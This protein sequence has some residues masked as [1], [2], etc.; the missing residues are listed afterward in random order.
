MLRFILW[1]CF[2]YTSIQRGFAQGSSN[3]DQG[4]GKI[5]PLEVEVKLG[6]DVILQCDAVKLGQNSLLLEWRKNGSKSAIF[7]KFMDF[8]PRID[9]RYSRRLHMINSSAILLSSA[10]ESDAG[11]YRCKTMQSATESAVINH[12]RWIVLKVTGKVG[13]PSRRKTVVETYPAV[14]DCMTDKD[15][16]TETVVYSWTKDGSDAL[17]SVGATILASGA[18]FIKATR[19]AYIGVYQCTARTVDSTGLVSYAGVK[20]FLDVQYAPEIKNISEVVAV[21]EGSDARLPCVADAN[22]ATEFTNWTRHRKD[23]RSARF[24]V[25]EKGALLIQDVRRTDAGEYSCTPYNKVGA[26]KTKITKLVLKDVPRFIIAPPSIMTLRVDD[27]VTLDCRATSES[28]V[29]LS[30]EREGSPLPKD[31]S[32][33]KN[34]K[35]TIRRIQ[36]DDYGIYTCIASSNDGKA[37]QST[38]LAVIS[39]PSKPSITSVTFN[40][41]TVVVRWRPG[42]DGGYPQKMEVWYRLFSDDDY[43]WSYSPRLS[44]SVTSY[45]IPG[46]QAGKPYLFSVRGV[47]REGLGLFSEMVEAKGLPP[48]LNRDSKKSDKP[49]APESVTLNITR[50]GYHVSWQYKD[51][52][53][54]PSV[55]KFVIEYREGNHSSTW[56][57][58]DDNVPAERKDYLFSAKLAEADKSYDF[59]VSSCDATKCSEPAYVTV[60]YRIAS[61]VFGASSSGS[62]IYPIIGG[63]LGAICGVLLIALFCF[64]CC[65]KRKRDKLSINQSGSKKVQFVLPRSEGTE[66]E[67]SEED[68]LDAEIKLLP[69]A[70]RFVPDHNDTSYPYEKYAKMK[71]EEDFLLMGHGGCYGGDMLRRSNV[72]N[73]ASAGHSPELSLDSEKVRFFGDFETRDG[74][75]AWYDCSLGKPASREVR[76]SFDQ[77][78]RADIGSKDSIHRSPTGSNGRKSSQDQIGSKGAPK[79]GSNVSLPEGKA[80]SGNLRNSRFTPIKEESPR[81]RDVPRGNGTLGRRQPHHWSSPAVYSKRQD[82]NNNS[83]GKNSDSDSGD[84]SSRGRTRRHR[85]HSLYEGKLRPISEQDADAKLRCT[86]DAD[87]ESDDYANYPTLKLGE[88]GAPP[89]SESSSYLHLDRSDTLKRSFPNRSKEW[90]EPTPGEPYASHRHRKPLDTDS[91]NSISPAIS[92]ATLSETESDQ[93]IARKLYGSRSSE[94]TNG[95]VAAT[96]PRAV[97]KL[98]S[99]DSESSSDER[100]LQR[101][102]DRSRK[103]SPPVYKDK[104]PASVTD[105]ELKAVDRL[106]SM[107][108]LKACDPYFKN[109]NPVS[110]S[111]S[112]ASSGIGSVPVSSC[113]TNSIESPRE[114]RPRFSSRTSLDRA[115]SGYNSPRESLRS[116]SLRPSQMS[117]SARSS[118]SSDRTSTDRTSSG[119]TSSRDSYENTERLRP[120]DYSKAHAQMRL[121]GKGRRSDETYDLDPSS[122]DLH[123]VETEGSAYDPKVFEEIIAMQ[124]A[125]G[126]NLDGSDSSRESLKEMA[127]LSNSEMMTYSPRM[128]PSK[129]KVDLYSDEEKDQRCTKLMAEYK[130]NK[131]LQDVKTRPGSQI[132]RT[133]DL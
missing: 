75:S 20:T 15:L 129:F 81:E 38:T 100:G 87:E 105:L 58:A 74:Q 40:G 52:P 55:E 64:C 113:E 98:K 24:A 2:L 88:G 120:E 71:R 11:I 107:E 42:Y 37:R 82:T 116:S 36:K 77:F 127:K 48:E 51:V 12:G 39:T 122:H 19:R 54:R 65:R 92:L 33:V 56:F 131:K 34:G 111:S 118:V 47:N 108:L 109:C 78:C 106:D 104:K 5:P 103:S 53:G 117:T 18:L 50:D 83:D 1:T 90:N 9:P 112:N 4:G 133:W 73:S 27:D 31:R 8:T 35:L 110:R 26:G 59:R 67:E 101:S 123:E 17:T 119:Y 97:K 10:K 132:Y 44:A 66:P 6:S 121:S 7:M 80:T 114:R 43:K 16:P 94:T 29:T 13:L 61:P 69:E 49:L 3:T 76:D 70:V 28:P 130:T 125:M 96:L 115:S 128:S 62:N 86:C 93:E 126:V 14:L 79:F 85:P 60:T 72:V 95:A 84:S 30:W 32:V 102:R 99:N 45:R 89:T 21:A 91:E 46:L 63:V 23:V 25:L 22:P 124:Q 57:R 68:F 41:S